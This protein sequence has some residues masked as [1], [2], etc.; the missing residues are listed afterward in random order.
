MSMTEK[1]KVLVTIAPLIPEEQFTRNEI[2]SRSKHYGFVPCESGTVWQESLTS[3]L[4]RL[5]WHHHVFPQHL[6]A[7]V[8]V[9]RLC[10]SYSRPQIAKFCQRDA[11]GVNGNGPLAQGFSKV[12]GVKKPS[13]SG[14]MK[15]NEKQ[16]HSGGTRY[17]L[18]DIVCGEQG[19]PRAGHQ[20]DALALRGM[21]PAG[22]WSKGT[23]ETL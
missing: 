14:R 11:M 21:P 6:V 23:R 15:R 8:V 19:R 4:N 16:L 17:G 12:E 9:P 13:P 3:Y 18:Y 5:A 1:P 22:G 2:P 7:E 10:H 20:A